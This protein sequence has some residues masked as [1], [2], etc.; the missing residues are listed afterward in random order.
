M[1]DDILWSD[2]IGRNRPPRRIADLS[3]NE[4]DVV[5]EIIYIRCVE[6]YTPEN[7]KNN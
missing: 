4:E 7:V 5:T 1:K 2:C 3:K 6:G